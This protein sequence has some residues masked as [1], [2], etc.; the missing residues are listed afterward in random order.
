[1]LYFTDDDTIADVNLLAELV[2]VFQND[3]VGCAS[4]RI[5]PKWECTPPKWVNKYCRNALLSL[6]DK[7]RS[8]F[9]RKNDFGVWGCHEAIRRDVFFKVGG[10]HPDLIGSSGVGDGETGMNEDV[11][12]LGYYFAYVGTSVIYHMIPSARMTQQYLYKRYTYNGNT[13]SYSDY[14]KKPFGK[15]E[16]EGL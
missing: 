12:K 3:K 8:T 15:K 16:A 5:L 7:G 1:M 14:R 2:K 6:N 11:K 4:G 10:V 9:I 13:H